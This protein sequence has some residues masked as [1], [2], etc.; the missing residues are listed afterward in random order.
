MK[1]GVSMTLRW[2][3]RDDRR[4]IVLDHESPGGVHRGPIFVE[5]LHERRR[6]VV[7]HHV[8]HLERVERGVD[9]GAHRVARR[10]AVGEHLLAD[11]EDLVARRLELAQPH[12]LLEL[13]RPRLPV[14]GGTRQE[15]VAQP[16]SMPVER[17]PGHSGGC[18]EAAG[19]RGI[20]AVGRRR[21]DDRLEERG[22][23]L[24]ALDV[25][26]CPQ[27]DRLGHPR[28]G[29]FEEARRLLEP[30]GDR[31]EPLGERREVAREER[32]ERLADLL[33]RPGAALPGAALRELV[34]RQPRL[35]DDEVAVERMLRRQIVR[36]EPIH[37]RDRRAVVSN[38][39]LDVLA[40]RR[41]QVTVVIVHAEVRGDHRLE[42]QPLAEPAVDGPLEAGIGIALGVGHRDSCEVTTVAR[43]T[44]R[45][46]VVVTI[47][48]SARGRARV[49]EA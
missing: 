7:L 25:D 23:G 6:V 41:R 36:D 31:G 12:D 13:L 19:E 49:D 47:R 24:R 27:A 28:L 44:R 38:E 18:L 4:Q 5:R 39:R 48:W 37:L 11:R 8:G 14:G 34:E 21:G 40:R 9:L 46:A 2:S 45:R 43:R 30:R 20:A 17:R 32:E 15:L 33:G 1:D 26:L 42:R 35:V 3:S 29:L 22:Q 10:D 16:G